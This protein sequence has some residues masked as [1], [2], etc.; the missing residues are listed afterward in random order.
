MRRRGIR[1]K[2]LLDNRKEI[3]KAMEHERG[4]TR[5]H[6]LVNSLQK[7]LWICRKIQLRN[8]RNI[9]CCH[10]TVHN[11][12]TM[13]V[14]KFLTRIPSLILLNSQYY[15]TMHRIPNSFFATATQKPNLTYSNSN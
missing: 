3:Q 13:T 11:R 14:L 4:S 7:R 6:C 9:F 10:Y 12:V 1:R 15:N 2:Q 8:A 5:S